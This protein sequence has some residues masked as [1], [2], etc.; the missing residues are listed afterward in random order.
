MPMN[1][2]LSK[3]AWL[4]AWQFE[5]HRGLVTALAFSPDGQRLV[6]ASEDSTALIWDLAA[7]KGTF[8]R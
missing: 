7:D 3:A 5:G 4:A 6:S 8:C 2:M 1:V